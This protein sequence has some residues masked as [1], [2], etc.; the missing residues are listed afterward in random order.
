M[1]KNNGK[2]HHFG[3]ALIVRLSGRERETDPPGEGSLVIEVKQNNGKVIKLNCFMDTSFAQMFYAKEVNVNDNLM[4]EFWL[5]GSPK[6][7]VKLE[8]KAKN[9][10]WVEYSEFMSNYYLVKGEVIE[11]RQHPAMEDSNLAI[12][13]CGLYVFTRVIKTAPLKVGDY[14]EKEGRLDVRIKGR[15]EK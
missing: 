3:K 4:V 7:S 8:G 1:Q 14:I 2:Y 15:I 10:S 6:E 12:I 11:L 5:A 13:D 9:I